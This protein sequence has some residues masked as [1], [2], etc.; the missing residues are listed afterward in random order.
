[1]T[2]PKCGKPLRPGVRFCG[3]CGSPVPATPLQRGPA[4]DAGAAQGDGALEQ[5]GGSLCPQCKS[6]VRPGAK[7]C[8]NCGYP[9]GQEEQQAAAARVAGAPPAVAA[10]PKAPA[11]RPAPGRLIAP[12]KPAAAPRRP[13]IWTWAL[14][15]VLVVACV[16]AVAA[17]FLYV[18]DPLGWFGRAT[19]TLLTPPTAAQVATQ[20]LAQPAAPTSTAIP[21]L[22]S[23]VT[24]TDTLLPPLPTQTLPPTL[25]IT[26][27]IIT[28]T[29]TF[30]PTASLTP[31]LQAD[32]LIDEDFS[33]L[34]MSNW[35]PWGSPHPL[36]SSGATGNWLDLKAEMP[37]TAGVTSKQTVINAPGVIIE[38]VAQLNPTFSRYTLTFE[39]D[40][41]PY[42]RDRSDPEDRATPG[43]L[44]LEI[45]KN[46]LIVAASAANNGC[47]IEDVA[48]DISHTYRF[49]I[50]EGQGVDLYLDGQL[51]PVCQIANMRVNP[52]PGH[53]SFTG[54]GWLTHVKVTI[55]DGP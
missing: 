22:E 36:V 37:N 6:P 45:R 9:L 53:I 33:G 41:L 39:W 44:H 14:A 15:S 19:A 2:C 17:G 5:P 31:S 7:F 32:I 18:R 3:N 29:A 34:L 8:N 42:R 46:R 1:M 4:D 20:T 51:Q 54:L 47:Q 21:T 27:A 43:A 28:P 24:P 11:P 12:P 38:F 13:S 23:T 10:P 49:Q 40:P 50:V 48:G 35:V 30:T 26:P 25:A 16:L 55:E 52:T